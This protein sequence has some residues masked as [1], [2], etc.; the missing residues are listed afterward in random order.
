MSY[1]DEPA[2]S[3]P[4]EYILAILKAYLN[5]SSFFPLSNCRNCFVWESL[6]NLD[7]LEYLR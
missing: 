3:C 7:N 2:G 5:S 6:L 1:F 4:E